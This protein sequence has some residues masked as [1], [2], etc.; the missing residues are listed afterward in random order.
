M[1][2]NQIYFK[3]VN[4]IQDVISNIHHQKKKNCKTFIFTVRKIWGIN[5]VSP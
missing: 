2:T 1:H 4:L 3:Q 5:V